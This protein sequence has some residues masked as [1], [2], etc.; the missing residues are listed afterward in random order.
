M[1][2]SVRRYGDR[3]FVDYATLAAEVEP[4]QRIFVDDGLLALD[5]VSADRNGEVLCRTRNGCRSVSRR[6]S[7]FLI[8]SCQ[9][10][11]RSRRAMKM[12][13]ASRR[14]GRFRLR[15]LCPARSRRGGSA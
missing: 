7:I 9:I 11:L 6:A 13:C 3:I 4:G 5:V 2:P 1:I 8:H 14:T 10:C 15:E 12:T